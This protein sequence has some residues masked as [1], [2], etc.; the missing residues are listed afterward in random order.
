MAELR[1]TVALRSVKSELLRFLG[2][3]YATAPSESETRGI[4]P[5]SS[6]RSKWT[7]RNV[8]NHFP[9]HTIAD[10]HPPQPRNSV[11]AYSASTRVSLKNSTRERTFSCPESEVWDKE[12]ITGRCWSGGC[13]CFLGPGITTLCKPAYLQLNDSAWA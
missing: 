1:L 4:H 3:Q 10:D 7:T 11:L 12:D 6:C 8:C 2:Y 9:R 13:A 5:P